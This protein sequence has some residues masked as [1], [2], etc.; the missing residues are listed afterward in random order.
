MSW[1]TDEGARLVS[2][3]K[4]HSIWTS[5]QPL[6]VALPSTSS[7]RSPWL[8]VKARFDSSANA[9]T[10]DRDRTAADLAERWR[11]LQYSAGTFR[12]RRAQA[13][14]AIDLVRAE[15]TEGELDRLVRLVVRLGGSVERNAAGWEGEVEATSR[16]VQVHHRLGKETSL[17][18]VCLAWCEVKDGAA[19]ASPGALAVLSSSRTLGSRSTKS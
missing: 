6:S 12:T 3:L 2:A 11:H 18:D 7:S 14:A 17:I 15:W 5:T 1:T 9:D 13:E 19:S 8:A 16:W 10:P 4:H